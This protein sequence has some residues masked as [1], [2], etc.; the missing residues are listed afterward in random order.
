M[1]TS[2]VLRSEDDI[3]CSFLDPPKGDRAESE[4]MSIGKEIDFLESLTGKPG[5]FAFAEWLVQ[6]KSCIEG[7]R[8]I[9]LGSLMGSILVMTIWLSYHHFAVTFCSVLPNQI[10]STLFLIGVD[11]PP[12]FNPQL[13]IAFRKVIM[14]KVGRRRDEVWE[15]VT[16]LEGGRKRWK[17][18]DCR[19][20]FAGG[21]SRIKAHLNK[22]KGTGIRPCTGKA[23]SNNDTE[24]NLLHSQGQ[25]QAEDQERTEDLQ[26]M[27]RYV[28]ECLR[29]ED[30]VIISPLSHLTQ[31]EFIT[32]KPETYLDSLVIDT[33]VEILTD[34]ERKKK[35]LPLNWYL[36]VTF[37]EAAKGNVSYFLNFVHCQKVKEN[38]MSDLESC[39]KIFI[40]VR[41]GARLNGHFY[42]YIIH[43]KSKEIE[44][45]DSLPDTFET[46]IEET[47]KKL[48]IA[49]EKLFKKVTFTEFHLKKANDIR[50]QPN[51]YDCGVFVIN[52][53]QQSDNYV[54]RDDSSIEFD[55]Q[56]EREDLALK[57]LNNDLNKE[58]KNLHD[59]ARQQYAQVETQDGNKDD[60]NEEDDDSDEEDYGD[61]DEEDD[62]DSDEE[63]YDSDEQGDGLENGMSIDSDKDHDGLENDL[64]GR[65][66][67]R[68]TQQIRKWIEDDKVSAIGVWGMGGS[69][70]T[71]L[72][73]HIY[74]KLLEEGDIKVIWVTVSQNSIYKLQE[75][76]ARS[77]KLDISE[78]FEVKRI[79]KKLYQA[80]KE[81]KQCVVI[82]DDVWDHFFLKDVGFSLSD[83]RIKLILTT[84]IWEVC[85]G[86]GCDQKNK[87]KVGC[88]GMGDGRAL[89][90]KTMGSYEGLS[91]EVK[92]I[93]ENVADE[94]EGL[95]LAIVRIATSM[96]GK[97]QV[98]E[99]SHML[100]CLKN[101]GHGQYEIDKWVFPI[102]RS[103]Y[104]FLSKKLQ[105]FF[106][107]CALSTG[108]YFDDEK[109]DNL[110]R[111]FV[112]ESID[113][114]KKLRL[115]YD[116]NYNM[117][118]R[119]KNHSMLDRRQRQTPY[120]MGWRMNKF[121]KALGI[122]I[123]EDTVAYA[124]KKL[125][126]IP[127]D[128]QWKD[129]LQNAFLTGNKIKA[130]PDGTYLQ[131]SQLSTLLL[132]GNAN[133]NYI[134]ND[135]FNNMPALKILDVSGT[136]IKRLPE[137]VS[138]LK[139]L[140]ALLLSECRKLSYIPSL[141]KLKQLIS[142]DLSDTA[143]TK[144]PM[145]LESLVD[146][147][148]LNLYCAYM[149]MSASFISKL[150][151]L[152]NLEII[153]AYFRDI[154]VFNTYVSFLDKHRVLTSY[155]LFLVDSSDVS[156][157]RQIKK[158][159]SK[160]WIMFNKMNLRNRK[161]VLPGDIK[162]LDIIDCQLGGDIKE[163]DKRDCLCSVVLS[164]GHTNNDNAHQIERLVIR[165]C[166]DVDYLCCFSGSC[167]FCS[168]SQ[169]V[170]R[171]RLSLLKDL[172]DIVSPDALLS[173]HQPSLFSRL[174][175]LVIYHCDSMETLMTPK[176]LVLL[177]NLHTIDVRFCG[178]MKEIVGE[179]D[180]S[181]M[182][183]GGSGDLSHPTPITL[184][185]LTSLELH[186]MPQLINFRSQMDVS[187]PWRRP[188]VDTV[189]KLK[190]INQIS[191]LRDATA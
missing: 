175:H 93:A 73:S 68:Y 146:L 120:D 82:L 183:L 141:S 114:T 122:G 80:F 115:Q 11:H 12:C 88:L 62:D 128:V 78:E 77:I 24:D 8:I 6:H 10:N 164:Y 151:N 106:L 22:V 105:R 35:T 99:W 52:Y 152:D 33:F 109:A 95:P 44:I 113:E 96:K 41:V 184:P 25:I 148:C 2:Q 108:G 42:L 69:G 38:Y 40:P 154:S 119:L 133:L 90:K 178:K 104:D 116:E 124:Y 101:L 71:A 149:L 142:L 4:R 191:R 182:E 190:L 107:Y 72:A 111:R 18:N 1:A 129:D 166:E 169:L 132:N 171:L 147:R 54:K 143:I 155:H 150:N 158:K 55:S 50:L 91:L 161:A 9:E 28:F 92:R 179:D 45:W 31:E 61:S 168:S 84:R 176:L 103:S 70:K 186:F 110:I 60:S 144:A 134:S 7:R 81:M 74:D 163:L 173:L 100:E 138:S 127:R 189:G 49:M 14:E 167:P 32:L 51:G 181:K 157:A 118:Y 162:E 36:P 126:K 165:N 85:E 145:G 53:M 21:A 86:M 130:I 56:K 66:F 75:V 137:S 102:L 97:K 23:N 37:S 27:K 131:C 83:N 46:E 136:C 59:K 112:Y 57:L 180:H 5:T 63:D 156:Y 177:Q 159:Y 94:C 89:F 123:A 47:T 187:F 16:L 174:T 160:K 188:Q 39:D 76:I 65:N 125:T 29:P 170:G 13:E 135:F 3:F 20:K 58:K 79:A 67:Q 48:L 185:R 117:L 98:G 26:M 153:V 121:L 15:R 34:I 172:K 139:C 87:I 19:E 17:C 30:R 64:I 140:T 43:L